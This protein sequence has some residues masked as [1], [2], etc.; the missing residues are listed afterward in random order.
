[1]LIYGYCMQISVCY[2]NQFWAVVT[3]NW[4]LSMQWNI[5]NDF[6]LIWDT[7]CEFLICADQTSPL[8]GERGLVCGGEKAS[9]KAHNWDLPQRVWKKK[10][11]SVCKPGTKGQA[12]K[13]GTPQD[14]QPGTD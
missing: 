13:H 2:A 1:M 3:I 4:Y 9:L 5:C 10:K 8:A 12:C 14:E 7:M 6:I 11:K